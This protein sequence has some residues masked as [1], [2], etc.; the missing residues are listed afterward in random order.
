MCIANLFG[1]GGA[2]A[3]AA[4]Q[5]KIAQQ[6]Q[7]QAQASIASANL[8]TEQS[9]TAAEATMRKAAASQGFASTIFGSGQPQTSPV[10][11]KALFGS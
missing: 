8:D 10:A 5:L 2:S 1:D 6:Q 3:L 9:R 4:Q 7:Q 11:F